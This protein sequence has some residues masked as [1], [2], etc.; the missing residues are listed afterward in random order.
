MLQMLQKEVRFYK[1][2]MIKEP[3]FFIMI[4]VMIILET[5]ALIFI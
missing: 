4:F 1:D 5:L 2:W 3:E